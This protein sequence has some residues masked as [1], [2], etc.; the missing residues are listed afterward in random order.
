MLLF[1]TTATSSSL[2]SRL[3]LHIATPLHLC[4]REC[5]GSDQMPAVETSLSVAVFR[6][7]FASISS[8]VIL[9]TPRTC[10]TDPSAFLDHSA[11]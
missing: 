4:A 10:A 7:F 9:T 3:L 11:A 8:A 1:D 2:L 5:P 6:H